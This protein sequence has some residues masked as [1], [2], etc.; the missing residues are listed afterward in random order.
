MV[1]FIKKQ[2]LNWLGHVERKTDDDITRIK[3]RKPVSKRP[4]G[5]PKMRWEEDSFWYMLQ[6][7]K[8]LQFF[9]VFCHIAECRSFLV[10]SVI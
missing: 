6:Y 5:R 2:G 4:T 7:S 9:G 1:G 10:C 3:R 8:V